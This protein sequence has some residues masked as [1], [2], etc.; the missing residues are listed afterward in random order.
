MNYFYYRRPSVC[1]QYYEILRPQIDILSKNVFL[2]LGSNL[3][4]SLRLASSISSVLAL[5]CLALCRIH[6]LDIEML[7]KS[8]V[9]AFGLGIFSTVK[10]T[11][12][13][14]KLDFESRCLVSFYSTFLGGIVKQWQINA[15]IAEHLTFTL[16]RQSNLFLVWV[17]ECVLSRDREYTSAILNAIVPLKESLARRIVQKSK[18]VI[19]FETAISAFEDATNFYEG[20]KSSLSLLTV[21]VC[22]FCAKT[23]NAVSVKEIIIGMQRC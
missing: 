10:Y 21:F 5:C 8:E 12:S 13:I 6:K 9:S 20:E 15:D 22:I 3:N 16:A 23:S 2:S 18:E 17:A 7:V 14:D 19:V 1:V 4:R 11:D